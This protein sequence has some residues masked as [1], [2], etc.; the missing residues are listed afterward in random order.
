MGKEKYV[1]GLT[2]DLTCGTKVPTTSWYRITTGRRNKILGNKRGTQTQ[3]QH[4]RTFSNLVLKGK[5]CKA[6]CF[7]CEQEMRG[8]GGY[9]LANGRMKNGALWIKP[10]RNHWQ[11]KSAQEKT[12]GVAIF[13]PMDITEE[14]VDSVAQNISGSA[15]PGETN[16]EDLQGWILKYMDRGFTEI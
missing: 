2:Q 1:T 10:L 3:E 12:L 6:V 16:S 9:Y 7:I 13:I 14:V 8:G 4:H 11:E 15:R 5:F